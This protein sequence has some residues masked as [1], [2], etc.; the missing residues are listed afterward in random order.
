[1]PIILPLSGGQFIAV[2]HVG[3]ALA[4][5]DNHIEVLHSK[6]K[7]HIWT[8]TSTI[9]AAGPEPGWCYRAPQIVETADGQL[10]MAATRF[11]AD[12][13]P[14]YHPETESLQRPEM[15]LFRSSDQ[16]HTWS[17]PQI[18]TV[19]FPPERYTA[20]CSSPL[21]VLSP[22]RWMYSFE[23]W[24]PYGFDGPPDQK[25]GALFSSDQGQSWAEQTI[26]ADDT[27]GRLHYWDQMHTVLPDG[28]LYNMF[29]THL[30]GTNEDINNHW[31]ISSDRGRTWTTPR[32][33]NLRGQMCV[34]IALADGRVG[35]IYNYRHEPQG[36]HLALTS[37][38]KHFDTERELV[39]Y[40][41]HGQATTGPPEGDAFVAKK[42]KI[43]FGRPGGRRLAEGTLLVWYWCTVDGVTQTRWARVAV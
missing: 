20:A 14:L 28:R 33:T 24:K 36:I 3:S 9:P 1:M 2:Q 6:D 18:V 12:G 5:D 37:D 39:V 4:S 17:G 22:D 11:V 8:T 21:L 38:L 32:R 29:W 19:D 30:A 16:G 43:A 23:T 34:P 7:G 31:S 35:A 15:L 25:A 40:D 41:A 10:V 42:V 13:R 26:I 27:T